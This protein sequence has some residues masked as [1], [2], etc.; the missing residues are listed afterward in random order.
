MTSLA[1]TGFEQD[2]EEVVDCADHRAVDFID[3]YFKG[4]EDID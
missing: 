2:V 3:D 1:V 4:R